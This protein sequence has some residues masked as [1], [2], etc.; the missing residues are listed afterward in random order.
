[1]STSALPAP[2]ASTARFAQANHFARSRP[3]GNRSQIA[4]RTVTNAARLTAFSS[5]PVAWGRPQAASLVNFLRDRTEMRP[6][7]YGSVRP[8]I[9]VRV[10]LDSPKYD[11]VLIPPLVGFELPRTNVLRN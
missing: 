10:G 6:S 11:L 9:G 8:M 1:M 5:M 7:V 2:Y 4:R 3:G